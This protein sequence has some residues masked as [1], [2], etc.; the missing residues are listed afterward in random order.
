MRL[1]HPKNLKLFYIKLED[2]MRKSILIFAFFFG[3]KRTSVSPRAEKRC[4]SFVDFRTKIWVSKSLTDADGRPNG[5]SPKDKNQRQT[6]TQTRS[7]NLTQ[8]GGLE[9]GFFPPGHE[10]T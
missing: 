1:V 8:P 4:F 10:I 7:V 2:A 5:P 3:H 6:Q 9:R